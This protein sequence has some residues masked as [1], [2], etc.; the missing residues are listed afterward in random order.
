MGCAWA[1]VHVL[2]AL[3]GPAEWVGLGHC[4]DGQRAKWVGVLKE[5]EERGQG[6]S[7][8]DD[9]PGR[10]GRAELIRMVA[11]FLGRDIWDPCL[12]DYMNP[13]W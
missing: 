7:G 2:C 10:G 13:R 5:W 4:D 8:A 11:R 1:W 3:R 9:G 6:E 12:L